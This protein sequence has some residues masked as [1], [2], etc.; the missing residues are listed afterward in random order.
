MKMK[1]LAALSLTFAFLYFCLP[2]ALAYSDGTMQH[3][4]S[5]SAGPNNIAIIDES[6]TLWMTGLHPEKVPVEVMPDTS[7]VSIAASDYAV[8]KKDRS[9]WMWGENEFGQLGNGTQEDSDTP[10][11]IMDD[12]AFV[13]T[14]YAAT[15][16]VKSDGS[17]WMWGASNNRNFRFAGTA[18]TSVAHHS[19]EYG[20]THLCQTTPL[21]VMDDVAMVALGETATAALKTDGTLW[22]WGSDTIGKLGKSYS[23]EPVQVMDGVA[24]VS[25]GTKHMAAL[26]RDG[27]LWTWGSNRDGQLGNGGGGDGT[28]SITKAGNTIEYATQSQPIQVMDGAASIELGY[29]Y[30]VA[31]KTDGS[32]WAWGYNGAAHLGN[33]GTGDGTTLYHGAFQDTYLTGAIQTVPAK[34]M[35]NVVRFSAGEYDTAAVKADNTV[36]TWGVNDKGQLGN[37]G[38]GNTVTAW[39]L[40]CQDVPAQIFLSGEIQSAVPVTSTTDLHITHNGVEQVFTDVNGAPVLPLTYQGT[41]YLPVRAVAGLVGLRADWDADTATV[42]LTTVPGAAAR[43][44]RPGSPSG[45]TS[46]VTVT[47]DRGMRVT[48]DGAA[49]TFRDANGQ[50]VYPLVYNGT[51][52][53][54]VRAISGLV[55]LSIEWDGTTNTVRLT[56][57]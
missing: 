14:G 3:D 43:Y 29:D 57:N 53:L 48:L 35:E 5:M 6:G 46:T 30:T 20:Y 41:T 54:P 18:L 49:Q 38:G 19:N 24:S 27:T 21:K 44:S 9:L 31:L 39:G 51:T 33:R 1:Q 50:A 45:V 7:A 17:L 32:L 13:V 42:L 26:K 56:E 34:I 25:A 15:A 8:I 23:P 36:W 40:A 28:T 4:T 52:Y 2:S 37:G 12:V 55:D 11:K 22:T 10:I 47:L 16:A